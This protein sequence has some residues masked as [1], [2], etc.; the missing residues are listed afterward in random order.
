MSP[1]ANDFTCSILILAGKVDTHNNL[2]NFIPSLYSYPNGAASMVSSN[3]HSSFISM[4]Y[5]ITRI[6]CTYIE[7]DALSYKHEKVLNK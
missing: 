4:K 1:V 7:I 3:F 5:G 6:K 2:Y